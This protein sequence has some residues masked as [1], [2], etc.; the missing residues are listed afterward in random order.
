M[1]KIVYGKKIKVARVNKFFETYD[2]AKKV[3]N[4][5]TV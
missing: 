1:E 4:G 2:T 3:R 5:I